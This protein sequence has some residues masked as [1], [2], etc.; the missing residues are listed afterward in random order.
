MAISSGYCI[1]SCNWII[2]SDHERITYIAG[3]CALTTHPRVSSV[4][5]NFEYGVILNVLIQYIA[6]LGSITYECN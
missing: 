2:D 1:G 3:S 4:T 6:G 5:N